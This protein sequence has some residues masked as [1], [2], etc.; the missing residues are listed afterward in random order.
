MYG[1]PKQRLDSRVEPLGLITLCS[2]TRPAQ[3]SRPVTW[4][5]WCSGL[6]DPKYVTA[7]SPS[8]LHG[9]RNGNSHDRP[10]LT[11]RI[12]PYRSVAAGRR[13]GMR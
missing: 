4:T 1:T 6:M 5:T 2:A 13:L 12:R 7:F 10:L 11:H 8:D 3:D 9:L